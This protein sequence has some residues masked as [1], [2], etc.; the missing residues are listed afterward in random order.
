MLALKKLGIHKKELLDI[1]TNK[2]TVVKQPLAISSQKST[3]KTSQEF[4]EAAYK[5]KQI[6]LKEAG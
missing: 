5:L 1:T 6:N 4:S 3:E 2:I